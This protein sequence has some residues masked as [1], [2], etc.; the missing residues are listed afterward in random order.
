MDGDF[1]ALRELAELA[2]QYGAFLIIDEAHSGGVFGPE[3]K[4]LCVEQQ[5]SEQVFARV[6]TFGKAYGSHG[7]CV[8]GSAKLKDY[9][10]NFAR[11]FIYTTALPAQSYNLITEAIGFG[12]D[13]QL[14]EALQANIAHFIALNK[15]YIRFSS[16][17]SPIQIISPER[18]KQPDI[19]MTELRKAGFGIKLIQSPTVPK[20]ME[21]I[22]VC[23]HSFNTSRELETFS[24]LLSGFS[25]S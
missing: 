3:G 8:L 9:L 18:I 25:P 14:R 4:G 19:L 12:R 5:I 24:S 1:A 17:G 10:V 21:R 16:P 20:G 13:Q 15:E 23:L 11:S 6:V 2:G 22:R 7:A